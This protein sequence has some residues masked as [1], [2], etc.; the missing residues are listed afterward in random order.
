MIFFTTNKAA[1]PVVS[2]QPLP[3]WLLVNPMLFFSR[4]TKSRPRSKQISKAT[5]SVLPKSNSVPITRSPPSLPAMSKDTHLKAQ[6][7]SQYSSYLRAAVDKEDTVLKT[8]QGKKICIHLLL[9]YQSPLDPLARSLPPIPSWRN[10]P[11]KTSPVSSSNHH[12]YLLRI[13]QIYFWLVMPSTLFG[14]TW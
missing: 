8:W 2:T 4:R 1:P 11:L 14:Y 7:I 3:R 6:R 10:Q 12:F 9:F 5:N 13:T